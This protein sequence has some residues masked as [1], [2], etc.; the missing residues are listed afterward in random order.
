MKSRPTKPL[1]LVQGHL[2]KAEIAIRAKAE[3]ELITGIQMKEGFDVRN[4]AIAHK[5]FVRL[6][7][8]LKIINKN[9]DLTGNIINTHCLVH[10]ECKEFEMLKAQIYT[11]I[12]TLDE[13]MNNHEIEFV[14]YITNKNKLLDKL[15]ACD[16]RIMEKR[17]MLLDIA[18]ESILT[19]QSALRT[20][21]KKEQP[22]EQ[23]A[24][25]TFLKKKQVGG[26]A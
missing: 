23:S 15:L 1:A 17:K 22:K 24:M 14:E 26:N 20:I 10:A 16:K 13:S 6:R 3:S 2:T 19:I 9:D 8:L 21:P 18:K 12:K 5:E 4:N 25:A 7:R 11:N